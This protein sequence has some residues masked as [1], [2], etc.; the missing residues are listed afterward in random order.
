MKPLRLLALTLS[1]IAVFSLITYS[2]IDGL[3][4]MRSASV[5]ADG[6]NKFLNSLSAEQKGKAVFTFNDE[7]RYDWHFVPRARKGLPLK[8]LNADQRKLAMEFLKTGLSASGYKKVTTIISLEPILRVLEQ[9]QG[10]SNM[11]RDEELYYF[12]VFGTPSV[13]EVW[14]WRVEGHHLSLNYTV[15][16]GDLISSTPHFFGAN[17]A[18]VKKGPQ[19]GLRALAGEEDQGRTLVKSL[20]EQQRA[21]A[22]FDKTAPRDILTTNIRRADPLKPEG[23][24]FSKLKK[25]QKDLLN[26]LLEEYLSRMPQDIADERRK[27]LRDA[28]VDKIH[29]AWAGGLERGE[30]HYYR[31]QGPTFL[32]EYDDTQNNA[33]HIHSVWRDFNGD[34]GA[35]LLRAHYTTTPHDQQISGIIYEEGDWGKEGVAMPKIL[36]KVKPKYTRE[37]LRKKIKG[38]VEL[39]VIFTSDGRIVI[40]KVIRDLPYG[41]T[42]QAI[43]AAQKIRFNPAT[44]DGQPVNVR[45]NLEFSFATY[46]RL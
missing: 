28:G 37:A 29:F 16:K 30:G 2:I 39:S 41:L 46:Q 11:V 8:E 23:L 43:V 21:I 17:P 45:A 24:P 10:R 18:E 5:M 44:K 42:D 15:V 4:R 1:M 14:G 35:D 13:N 33:N 22:I 26:K 19:T 25:E 9:E 27:K 6:A 38:L 32:I 34:F 31:L 12:S 20:D 7:Q 40:D 36:Y 3:A